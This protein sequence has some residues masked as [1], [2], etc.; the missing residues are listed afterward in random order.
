MHESTWRYLFCL[1]TC[2]SPSFAFLITCGCQI[3]ECWGEYERAYLEQCIPP[4]HLPIHDLTWILTAL[5]SIYIEKVLLAELLNGLAD[6]NKLSDSYHN[7]RQT[8]LGEGVVS[9]RSQVAWGSLQD[10]QWPLQEW[11]IGITPETRE[12][13]DQLRGHASS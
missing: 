3:S 6:G 8:P 10:G 4:E 13:E 9:P 5:W 1:F 12:L 11:K 7:D 2:L